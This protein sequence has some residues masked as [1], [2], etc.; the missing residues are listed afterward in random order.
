MNFNASIVVLLDYIF[1]IPVPRTLFVATSHRLTQTMFQPTLSRMA[2]RECGTADGRVADH[3]RI[4]SIA[5]RRRH[6]FDLGR[7][8]IGRDL[9]EDGRRVRATEVL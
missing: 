3:Q 4:D 7:P 2:R 1:S 6:G 8:K 5:G 9:E